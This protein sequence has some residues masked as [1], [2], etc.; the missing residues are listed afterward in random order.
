VRCAPAA[1]LADEGSRSLVARLEVPQR[2]G[3]EP[4]ALPVG[5]DTK[6][7]AEQPAPPD[8]RRNQLGDGPTT[9]PASSAPPVF[10]STMPDAP[11]VSVATIQALQRELTR[12]GCY[13]GVIDGDW[14]PASRYA[15]ATFTAAVNAKLPVDQP[16][17]FLLALSRQHEGPVCQQTSSIATASATHG[18]R[19]TVTASGASD[20]SVERRPPTT[21]VSAYAPRLTSP[22]RIVRANGDHPTVD[23]TDVAEMPLPPS[24]EMDQGTKMALGAKPSTPPSEPYPVTR[25]RISQQKRDAARR[26]AARNRQNQAR[27]RASRQRWTRQVVQGIDLSG[28]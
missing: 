27:K 11:K 22:P 24:G 18:W 21:G 12:H 2:G 19:A 26:A 25:D 7:T 13:A 8:R 6:R 23:L 10:P 9:L 4:T 14:G 3:P 28:S 1:S 17:A 15:A 5:P 16:N 20:R